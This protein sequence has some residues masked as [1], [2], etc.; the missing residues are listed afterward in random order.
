MSAPK[1]L[2]TKD[3]NKAL[4]AEVAALFEVTGLE[5]RNSTCIVFHQYGTVNFAALTLARANQLMA[6]GF[7]HLQPKKQEKDS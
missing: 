3:F 6:Q 7:P 4:P 1:Y 2:T 5:K